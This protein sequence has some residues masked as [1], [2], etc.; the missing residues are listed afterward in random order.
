[1]TLR[2]WMQ[3]PTLTIFHQLFMALLRRELDSCELDSCELDSCELDSCEITLQVVH[4][5]R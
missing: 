2:D 4:V 1:M 5:E 3:T